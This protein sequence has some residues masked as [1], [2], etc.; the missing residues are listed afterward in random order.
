[1]IK[2]LFPRKRFVS[3]ATIFLLIS[4]FIMPTVVFAGIPDAVAREVG[5]AALEALSKAAASKAGVKGSTTALE[6]ANKAWY[7]RA[8][9]QQVAQ[10]KSAAER[11]TPAGTPGWLKATVGA[12]LFVSGADLIFQIYDTFRIDK[13]RPL[14]YWENVD[15]AHT[16]SLKIYSAYTIAVTYIGN[17][18]YCLSG[19]EGCPL[20]SRGLPPQYAMFPIMINEDNKQ[21]MPPY[22]SPEAKL[23]FNVIYVDERGYER[24]LATVGPLP[25]KYILSTREYVEYYNA[26]NPDKPQKK[27]NE[28]LAN[29]VLVAY[30]TPFEYDPAPEP[31]RLPMP[32]AMKDIFPNDTE[33]VE[34]VFP[35]PAVYP[36]AAEAIVNNRAIVTNPEPEPAPSTAPSPKPSPEPNPDPEPQPETGGILNWLSQFWANFMK[37]L[38]DLFIPTAI[39]TS[40]MRNVWTS[41]FPAIDS[42]TGSLKGLLGMNYTQTAPHWEFNINGKWYTMIDLRPIPSSWITM[43]RLFIRIGIWSGLLFL[44]LR[45]WRPRPHVG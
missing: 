4:M 42:I 17:D 3:V 25:K 23:T 44:I 35:D 29:Q 18:N 41:R 24:V 22:N 5:E 27:Y 28:A 30:N 43:A 6:R 13:G 34:I 32:D 21:T 39:D 20:I 31:K 26:K 45:E 9:E 15:V 33:A 36:N 10:L 16:E 12:G 2:R 1:M 38:S 19:I 37:T 8:T 40:P 14:T 11:A 7:Q